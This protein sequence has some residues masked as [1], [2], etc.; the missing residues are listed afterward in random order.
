MAMAVVRV[1]G[2]GMKP[3]VKLP[4]ARVRCQKPLQQSGLARLRLG[5]SQARRVGATRR[6]VGGWALKWKSM[7]AYKTL[8]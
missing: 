2:Y 7:N 8:L 6:A 4:R 3:V 5:R 1:N